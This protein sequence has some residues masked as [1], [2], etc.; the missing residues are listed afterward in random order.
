MNIVSSLWLTS[1]LLYYVEPKKDTMSIKYHIPM[2]N[3]PKKCK[4]I[5]LGH[6]RFSFLPLGRRWS[7]RERDALHLKCCKAAT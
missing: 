4:P 3:N 6:S 5:D 7:V 1:P 2:Y